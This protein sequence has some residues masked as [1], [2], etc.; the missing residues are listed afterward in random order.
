MNPKLIC[1]L[2]NLGSQ[3][4]LIVY[5][6]SGIHHQHPPFSMIFF[7]DTAW[8]IKASFHLEPKWEGGMYRPRCAADLGL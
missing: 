4:E 8:P 3:D 5:A 7:S 6:S 2:A 1:L